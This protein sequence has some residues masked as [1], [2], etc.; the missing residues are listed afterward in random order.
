MDYRDWDQ[1]AGWPRERRADGAWSGSDEDRA[2]RALSRRASDPF[3]EP[4]GADTEASNVLRGGAKARARWYTTESGAPGAWGPVSDGGVL[5][6][7]DETGGWTGGYDPWADDL[8]RGRRSEPGGGNGWRS[9]DETGEWRGR[10]EPAAWRT[11]TETTGWRLP[12]GETAWRS[13][14]ETTGWQSAGD[15]AGRRPPAEPPTRQPAI[16]GTAWPTVPERD[17]GHDRADTGSWVRST[18]TSVGRTRR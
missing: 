14:S 11:T 13:T 1:S 3:A 4:P 12:G 9:S 15:R 5:E 6:P 7:V 8:D 10:T 2:G 18:D 17:T 16:S